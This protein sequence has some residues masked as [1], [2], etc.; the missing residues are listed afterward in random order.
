MVDSIRLCVLT[1]I[2]TISSADD[3]WPRYRRPDCIEAVQ[4][5]EVAIMALISGS[6]RQRT[7]VCLKVT[8]S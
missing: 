2:A 5:V 7:S 1:K 8:A 3:E 4:D 6:M